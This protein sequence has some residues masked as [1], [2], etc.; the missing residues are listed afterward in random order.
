MKITL[1]EAKSMKQDVVGTEHLLM[2]ILKNK[3]NLVTQ[4]LSKW[5][6]T[7]TRSI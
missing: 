1:L 7:H 6:V 4:M 2:S 5:D 3:E